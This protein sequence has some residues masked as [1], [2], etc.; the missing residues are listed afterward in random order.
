MTEEQITARIDPRFNAA[1]EDLVRRGEYGSVDQFVD[2]AIRL[3]LQL[4]QAPV[5]GE[6]PGPHPFIAFFE[7][8]RGRALLRELMDEALGR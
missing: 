3:R 1:I 4:D 6:Q 7:S 2:R 5:D 8:P